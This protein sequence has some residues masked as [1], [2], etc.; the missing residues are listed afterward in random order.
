MSKT[1]YEDMSIEELLKAMPPW[2][3]RKPKPTPALPAAAKIVE[4]VSCNPHVPLDRQR[5]RISDAQKQLF[6]DEHRRLKEW[7]S[8]KKH[9][10]W[11]M[12]RQAALDWHMEQKRANEEWE[13]HY[14]D[15]PDG[16]IEM[17]NE[18]WQVEIKEQREAYRRRR[19][20]ELRFSDGYQDLREREKRAAELEA[21]REAE[22]CRRFVI[23][24]TS[25]D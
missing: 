12:E 17:Y 25:D 13:R 14:R 20:D 23:E 9:E 15:D 3:K 19:Q 2:K 4:L 8:Q 21:K 22:R 24:G 16:S 1:K 11:L 7:E 6:E 10:R 5:E 18:T